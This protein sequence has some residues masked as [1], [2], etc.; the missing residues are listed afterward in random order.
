MR[1]RCQTNNTHNPLEL[2]NGTFPILLLRTH[3]SLLLL[4]LLAWAEQQKEE[5]EEE[6]CVN[7]DTTFLEIIKKEKKRCSSRDNYGEG[8]GRSRQ[9][10][11]LSVLFSFLC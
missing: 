3:T 1:V 5:E 7:I 6:E 8:G 2:S 9:V 10:R 11:Q 4:L